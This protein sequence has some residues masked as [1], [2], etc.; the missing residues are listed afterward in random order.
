MKR[1]VTKRN[2]NS[3]SLNSYFSRDESILVRH[4]MHL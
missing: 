4:P 3:I 1:E 2:N